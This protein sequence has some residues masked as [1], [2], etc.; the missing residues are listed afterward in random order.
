L[1]TADLSDA[2]PGRWQPCSLPWRS[3]GG[4][5]AFSG[6]AQT[7]RCRDDNGLVRAA[8]SEPGQ[9]RVLVVDGGGSLR[10]A[11]VGDTLA[12]LALANGWAGVLVHGAVRDVVALSTMPIAV[13]ALGTNP[14]RGARAGTGARGGDVVFGGARFLPGAQVSADEDG[15][16]V[17]ATG[18][19]G[20]PELAAPAS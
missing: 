2:D 8:L 14:R 6:P 15:V 3:F 4:V 1:T 12:G 16:L 13:F 11:L 20:A 7:V 19:A 17:E 5:P 9:Q 10:T 18:P